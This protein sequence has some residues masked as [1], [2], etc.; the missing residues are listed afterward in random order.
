MIDD[1]PAG[2]AMNQVG[3]AADDA[4]RPRADVRL[5]PL[6]PAHLGADRLGGQRIAGA[7]EHPVG[8][9]EG[10][11]LRDL[12][13]RPCVDAVEDRRPQRPAVVVD[14]K[15]AGSDAGRPDRSDRRGIDPGVFDQATTEEAESVPPIGF[16]VVLGEPRPRHAHLVLALGGGGDAPG[17]V[18]KHALGGEAADVDAYEV[19]HEN[20]RLAKEKLASIPASAASKRSARPTRSA[21]SHV[22]TGVWV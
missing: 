4:A 1:V 5:M 14:G 15:H 18:E 8:A 12:P 19:A 22:S 16:G 13:A 10:V 21:R 6:K 9:E 2:E 11:E 17:L 3:R 7:L 20:L